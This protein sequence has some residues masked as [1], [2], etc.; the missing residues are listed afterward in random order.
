M[1]ESLLCSVIVPTY[2]RAEL[3]DLT[4]AALAEQTVPSDRFEVL[5]VDDGSTD[6]TEAVAK[7]YASRLDLR[8]F[9]QP[10]EGYRVAAA[11]NIGITNARSDIC[12]F[13]DCGVLAH[14]ECLQAHIDTHAAAA[15]PAAVCGYVHGLTFDDSGSDS[16]RAAADPR[17]PDEAIAVLAAAPEWADPR[18]A[19]YAKY[20]DEFGDLPAPWVVYWTCNASANTAQLREVGMFDEAYRS[21]GAEDVDVAFRLHRAGARFLLSRPASSVHWPHPKYHAANTESVMDN[22]RHFAASYDDPGVQ[23]VGQVRL[24]DINYVLLSRQG[25]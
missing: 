5:V 14:S 16:L 13:I 17:R 8:Y 18:E 11:R 23:L 6:D 25:G 12:V 4:L 19:F 1:S 21:W 20:S 22:Y 3:L 7:A 2:N 15:R 10:D 9:F 24:F